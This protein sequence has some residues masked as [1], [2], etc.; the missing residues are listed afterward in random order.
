MKYKLVE[1]RSINIEDD[2]IFYT[3]DKKIIRGNNTLNIII[4]SAKDIVGSKEE[5]VES[6]KIAIQNE[7]IDIDEDM[8]Y[9]DINFI[10]DELISNGFLEKVFEYE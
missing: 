7:F 3:D 6:A 5:I 9:N 8:I 10:V 2:Y 4:S 1:I